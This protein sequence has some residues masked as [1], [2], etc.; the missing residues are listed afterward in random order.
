MDDLFKGGSEERALK[1]H[2]IYKGLYK[3]WLKEERWLKE[4]NWR[5][6]SLERQNR[7]MA[8]KCKPVVTAKLLGLIDS[9]KEH[10]ARQACENLINL[11]EETEKR[12]TGP[13][14]GQEPDSC[15][16][17]ADGQDATEL[18]PEVASK[19]LALLAEEKRCN[20]E[21]E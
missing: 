2:K 8:A 18:R 6:E 20:S 16:E 7:I 14:V 9:K 19:M 13:Q 5:I 15:F 11:Q 12:T 4:F 3:K 17:S 1:R 10:T 21:L